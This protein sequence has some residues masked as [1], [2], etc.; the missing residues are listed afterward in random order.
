MKL[1]G[2]IS[3][4]NV[5]VLFLAL[6][7]INFIASKFYWKLDFT[8]DQLYTLSDGSKKIIK[9]IDDETIIKY[10]FSRSSETL[11]VMV[12]NYGKRVEELLKEFTAHSPNLIV[13]AY[14]PKPDSDEEE[15]AVKYGINGVQ[16]G[17]GESFY[18]GAAVLYL[19]KV[20]KIPFFDPRK[21]N[22]L[23]Y[24]IASMLSKLRDTGEKKILGI[25]SPLSLSTPAAVPGMKQN[26]GKEDWLFVEE[27]RKMFTIKIL[28]KDTDEI[29]VDISLLLVLHPK[30]IPENTEYAVEQYILAGGKAVLAVDPS[31]RSDPMQKSP[32]ARYGIT[33]ANKSDLKNIFNMLQVDFDPSKVVVDSDDATRVNTPQGMIQYPFWLSLGKDSFNKDIM[34]TSMLN[35]VLFVEPGLFKLKSD[36]SYIYTSLI[37]SSSSSS[38]TIDA[39][40]LSFISPQEYNNYDKLDSSF[41]LAGMVSGKFKSVF[42][43]KPEGSQYSLEHVS[44]A[45]KENSVLLIADA[46]FLNS[47]YSLRKLS[48]LGQTILQPINQNIAFL[49]NILDYVS[50][51]SDLISI[52]SRGTFNRPF[53]RVEEIEKKAQA[54]WFRVEKELTDKI[55]QVQQKLNKIQ[56]A[57][58]QDNQ[59]VLS[60]EQQ[61][62]INKFKIEQ[63]QFKRKRREVRKNLRQDIERL[64]TVL[65]LLNM[66]VVPTILLLIGFYVYIRRSQGKPIFRRRQE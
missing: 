22:F 41:S 1:K 30:E 61:D 65:T 51:S 32:Y 52:R 6:L 56:M 17:G 13:E 28:E 55:Q 4:S 31:A 64:G 63:M 16:A 47:R 53:T 27:L 39:T 50:G 58:T 26:S 9:A 33:Q 54:K 36:S 19:D 15:M 12:K 60:R 57:K 25:L 35:S 46:D 38:G 48:F 37:N 11:P 23:E 8:Q 34:V 44:V 45:D 24:E 5:L 66:T 62:E 10:F 21:E 20:Y 43:E 59:L 18:M 3:V 2:V 14:D 49:T 40:K 42:T 7:S 29:S